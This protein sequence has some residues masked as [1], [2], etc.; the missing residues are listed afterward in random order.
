MPNI[1]KEIEKKFLEAEKLRINRNFQGAIN[2]LEKLIEHNPD[3]L[4]ALN[5]IA[6]NYIE[7]KNFDEAEKYYKKCLNI[8]PDELIFINNLA[9]VFHDTS[10]YKKAIPLLQ[11]SLNINSE[12]IEIMKIT[13]KC[14]FEIDLRK[15]LDKFFLKALKIFPKDK[16][17]KYYYGK[18]L[19]RMNKH[20]DGLNIL[21]ETIG[22]IEF[23]EKKFKVI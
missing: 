16:T 7:L 23:D 12:Q 1:T 9:K 6:L 21:K 11:K 22:V 15:E 3:F 5:N 18:N 2:I 20:I 19:L 17:L 8:K 14:L 4:P 13:A 10:N